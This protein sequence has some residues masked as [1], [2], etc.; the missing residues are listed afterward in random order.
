MGGDDPMAMRRMLSFVGMSV[1]ALL[2]GCLRSSATKSEIVGTWS[3]TDGAVIIFEDGGRFIAQN[4][5][6]RVVFHEEGSEDRL[7][8]EGNWSL[9]EGDMGSEVELVFDRIGDRQ[10]GYGIR[11]LTAC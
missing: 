4:L 6:H 3:N 10:H 7:S 5:P 11:V 1:A 8:G 2:G 9:K